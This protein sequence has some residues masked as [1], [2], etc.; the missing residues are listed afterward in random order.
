MNIVKILMVTHIV[1]S[2]F[3]L[4]MVHLNRK[5]LKEVAK[6]ALVS[7]NHFELIMFLGCITPVLSEWFFFK[8]I[9]AYIYF[10]FM[11]YIYS[12]LKFSMIENCAVGWT[13][14]SFKGKPVIITIHLIFIHWSFMLFSRYNR[15]SNKKNENSD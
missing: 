2:L 5:L 8:I 10:I 4:I 13:T 15:I 1:I 12:I 6:D 7:D 11:L 9:K 3:L 14:Q